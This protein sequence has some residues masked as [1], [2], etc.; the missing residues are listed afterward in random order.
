[1]EEDR[2]SLLLVVEHPALYLQV[3]GVELAEVQAAWQQEVALVV[4]V[5]VLVLIMLVLLVLVVLAGVLPQ[6]LLLVAAVATHAVLTPFEDWLEGAGLKGNAVQ[7]EQQPDGWA[8]GFKTSN[9][10]FP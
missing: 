9:Q 10:R 7:Q 2:Q 4:V 3:V 5:A 6:P 1:V 8:L